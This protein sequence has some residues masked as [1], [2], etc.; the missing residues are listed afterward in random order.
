M[1]TLHAGWGA[2][3][4]QVQGALRLMADNEV[5]KQAALR[6]AADYCKA[7]ESGRADVLVRNRLF[8]PFAIAVT[9]GRAFPEVEVD[10]CGVPELLGANCVWRI[11]EVKTDPDGV[12]SVSARPLVCL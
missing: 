6:L 1:A 2:V 5:S 9:V 7:A 3:Q 10:I 12:R 4:Q 8:I 11:G